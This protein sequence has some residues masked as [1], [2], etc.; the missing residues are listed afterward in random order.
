[1]NTTKPM[2]KL[3]KLWDGWVSIYMLVNNTHYEWVKDVHNMETAKR[4]IGEI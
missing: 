3:E 1:M 2:Y 4:F